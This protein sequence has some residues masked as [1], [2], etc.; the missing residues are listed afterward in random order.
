VRIGSKF[1]GVHA[2]TVGDIRWVAA[3]CYEVRI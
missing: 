1:I 2:H 3:L